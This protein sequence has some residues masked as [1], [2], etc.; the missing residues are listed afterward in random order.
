MAVD[1]WEADVATTDGGSVH[2]RPIQPDDGPRIVAFHARQSSESIYLRYFSARPRLSAAEV[3]HFTNVDGRDRVAFVALLDDE[4]IGVGRYDRYKASDEA[5]IAFF[6]D[7]A[8]HGRGLATILLE[9]LAAAGRA[10]GIAAFTATVLPANRKMLAVFKQVGFEPATRFADGVIEVRFDIA[11]TDAS[12]AAVEARALRAEASTV[13][14]LLEPRSVAVIGA[15]RSPG[16]IGHEILRRLLAHEFAGPVY[17]VNREALHV[18]GVRAWPSVF[19]IPDQIDLAVIAVPAEDVLDAVEECARARVGAV[20][21][22]STGFADAG[23]DGL[24]R[25]QALVELARR[26]GIRVLGPASVGVVNTDPEV[27]LHASFAP[28][29]LRA[30]SVALCL[31]SGT[32]GVGIAEQAGRLGL[33]FSNFVAVGDRVDVSGND[34]LAWWDGDDRTEVI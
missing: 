31:Q 13:A 32:I 20:V 1:E 6:I 8:H 27:R 34:L 18:A 2:V 30:G 10:N 21:V 9:Y 33:G 7:D 4:L 28:L 22:V 19:D 5:E 26:H 17:P 12:A 11:P 16:S 23:P 14:R 15:G 3:R 29:E 24:E 25:E